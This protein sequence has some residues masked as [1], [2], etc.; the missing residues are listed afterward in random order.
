[1]GGKITD[2]KAKELELGEPD[3]YESGFP[4]QQARMIRVQE[5]LESGHLV[6]TFSSKRLKMRG[7][8]AWKERASSGQAAGRTYRIG[9][10]YSGKDWR[11]FGPGIRIGYMH[12]DRII[13]DWHQAQ[14]DCGNID[15]WYDEDHHADVSDLI[16]Q[17]S[18]DLGRQVD[19]PKRYDEM[20]ALAIRLVVQ[21][22]I[23]FSGRKY[24]DAA[25]LAPAI[26][27]ELPWLHTPE[28]WT[29]G[30]SEEEHLIG[31]LHKVDDS[32]ADPEFLDDIPF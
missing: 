8:K 6:V 12:L 28:R 4:S 17:C 1:M 27:R 14:F 11:N 23:R 3:I 26:E 7:L 21:S 19:I 15:G 20:I 16:R 25:E 29:F 24:I 2:Q 31:Q 10:Y 30:S 13:D 9:R 18:R 32:S 22:T 5:L